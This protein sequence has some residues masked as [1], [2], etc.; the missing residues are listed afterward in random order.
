MSWTDFTNGPAGIFGFAA[1]TGSGAAAT[2][3][4]SAFA[5]FAANSWSISCS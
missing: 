3:A 4:G 1:S 2:A 5:R